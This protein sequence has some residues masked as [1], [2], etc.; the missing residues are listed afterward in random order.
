[1]KDNPKVSVIIP[2]YNI[3]QYLSRCIESIINQTYKNIEIILVD[4][5]SPDNCGRICDEYAQKDNKIKVIHKQN[6]GLV[7][8]RNAGYK[9]VSGDWVMYV[10]GDDWIDVNTC[11]ELVGYIEKYADIDVIF[12]NCIQ[13]LD[14]HSIKG[15]WEWTCN[16][17]ERLY[18]GEECN[19]LAYNTLIYKSGIATACC[20]L[21]RYDFAQSNNLIHNAVLKQGIEGVEF[22]F[23]I[24]ISTKRALFIK[25][26]F[27]HYRYNV[28]S[29]SK[30]V[31]EKNTQYIIAGFIEINNRISQFD[32]TERECFQ[33]ALYQRALYI[34]I[35]IALNTYFHKNNKD[36]FKIKKKKYKD[37]VVN[38]T[39]FRE[40][41][42]YVECSQFDILRKITLHIIKKE[43]Y[44]LLPIISDLKNFFMKRGMYSY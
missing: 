23:R 3:E 34:L 18:I 20:K 6:R 28:N 26:Y 30:K 27:Y 41:L 35:A 38:N 21:I 37:I 9:A 22:S 11:E 10:D 39:F 16:E 13:E 5:G 25:K 24:F 44:F 2:I 17:K 4:D 8:A 15:K 12:W 32:H 7:S 36:P 33:S 29:I 19:N 42:N 40:A 14:C 1:M 31:D 43:C